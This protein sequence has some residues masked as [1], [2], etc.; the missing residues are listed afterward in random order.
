MAAH[1]RL[2]ANY[3]NTIGP[4]SC[5]LQVTFRMHNFLLDPEL[6]LNR[7]LADLILSRPRM[8]MSAAPIDRGK[9]QRR[10]N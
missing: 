7:L 2:P 9:V 8:I 6:L 10:C 5:F 3:S 1:Y 4:F